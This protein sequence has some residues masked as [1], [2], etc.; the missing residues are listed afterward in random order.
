MILTIVSFVSVIS[1]SFSL[2]FGLVSVLV[3]VSVVLFVVPSAVTEIPS[4]LKTVQG[5]P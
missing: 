5:Q 4:F 1:V 2:L 3:V